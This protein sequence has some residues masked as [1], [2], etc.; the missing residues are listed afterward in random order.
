MKKRSL[1]RTVLSGAVGA[2]ILTLSGCVDLPGMGTPA[3]LYMLSPKSSFAGDLPDVKWQLVVELPTAPSGLATPNIALTHDPIQLQYYAD[4]KWAERA[5]QMVQTLIVESFENSGK[6]IAVGRQ[7][8]GLRSDFNLKSDLR[9][10][11]AEYR[12]GSG[13]PIAHVRINAKLIKQPRRQIIASQAFEA[14][15]EAASGS[16]GDIVRAFDESLG[17]VLRRIVEWTLPTAR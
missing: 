11:Q 9:E 8:I 4:A 12:Q 16:M 2:A 6:I 10:F 1:L 15:V 5:P 3:R 13:A 14:N 7:A 17:K